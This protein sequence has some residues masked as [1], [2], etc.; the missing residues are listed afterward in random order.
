MISEGRK[1]PWYSATKR[2]SEL[3]TMKKD[4]APRQKHR[5]VVKKKMP[6]LTADEIQ[7]FV[8]KET[9]TE[10]TKFSDLYTF[11]SFI[12]K[13]GFGQVVL[14]KNIASE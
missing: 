9:P 14:A 11:I 3:E 7:N 1:S 5:K 4:D 13:G 10:T 12:G 6:L 2:E 8:L